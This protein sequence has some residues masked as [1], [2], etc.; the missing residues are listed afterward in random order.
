MD[1]EIVA[2][3]D[4]TARSRWRLTATSRLSGRKLERRGIETI[5]FDSEGLIARVEVSD[6]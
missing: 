4:K 6:L 1:D 5:T 2:M 3:G